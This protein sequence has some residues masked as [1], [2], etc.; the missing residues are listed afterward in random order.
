M[1]KKFE[2]VKSV[3]F[4]KVVLSGVVLAL[5]QNGYID[6][7]SAKIISGILLGSVT[8]RTIDRAFEHLGK[9]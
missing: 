2:F 5:G 3:R 7:E 6:L 4:W 1:L 9:K 8:I